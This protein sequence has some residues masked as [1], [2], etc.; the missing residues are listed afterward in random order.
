M[1]VYKKITAHRSESVNL[2]REIGKEFCKRFAG[3]GCIS[4]KD[5][6]FVEKP[7]REENYGGW[8]DESG[9]RKPR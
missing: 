9:K 4:E 5:M 6:W 7:E 8:V 1:N 2:K 3:I